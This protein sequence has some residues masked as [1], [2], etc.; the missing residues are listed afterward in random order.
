MKIMRSKIMSA[1]LVAALLTPA[2]MQAQQRFNK[3]LRDFVGKVKENAGKTAKKSALPPRIV[4]Y[5]M[6]AA[7]SDE[8]L[9]RRSALHKGVADRL[10]TSWASMIWSLTAGRSIGTRAE[11]VPGASLIPSSPVES[12]APAAI[13]RV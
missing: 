11:A 4:D 8:S 1:C 7:G 6:E 5:R 13:Q 9:A 12:L 2:T 10:S 3:A